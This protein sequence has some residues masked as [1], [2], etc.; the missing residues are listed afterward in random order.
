MTPLLTFDQVIE[1]ANNPHVLLGNGFSMAYE[2]ERFSFT[3]LLESAVAD[4][5][6]EKDSYV[7]KVFQKLETADFESVMRILNETEKVVDV[8]E[9]DPNLRKQLLDDA[10]NLKEYLVTI[11]T[12][13]HPTNSTDIDAKKKDSCVTFLRNFDKIFT[14][15][16]DLLLYWSV[17]HSSSEE[18]EFTDGFGNDEDSE[19]E[20]YVVY[21]NK[22]SF[23]VHYLHGALHLFDAG[24]QIIKKTYKNSGIELITQVR[25]SLSSGI[26]PVFISEGDSSQKMTKI[27]HNGYLNHCYRCL[28]E[29]NRDL[30]ILGTYLKD[31]DNHILD[32]LLQGT[33]KNIFLGVSREDSPDVEK[34]R[35]RIAGFNRDKTP[36][37]QK[38]LHLYDYRTANIWNNHE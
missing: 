30:V 29:V 1:Q 5:I 20:G 25:N 17:I 7:Y 31:N 18:T 3:T 9:A 8:Y 35:S 38:I 6:I 10:D 27:I 11:I 4:K 32:G 13:N 14:L 36:A 34:I 33:V 23:K 21:K 12:N 24:D 2:P 22:R 37:K 26:Y 19:H 28:K 16:Y 15:N